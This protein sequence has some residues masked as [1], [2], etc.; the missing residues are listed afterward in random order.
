VLVRAIC[1]GDG[2]GYDFETIG[3][4]TRF[5]PNGHEPD[6]ENENEHEH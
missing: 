1:L 2:T 4:N 6:I 5:E 3:P